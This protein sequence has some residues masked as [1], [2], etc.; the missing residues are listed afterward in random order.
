MTRA[1]T[2]GLVLATLVVTLLLAF[3]APLKA[4]ECR[5]PID[6]VVADVVSE[7]GYLVDLIDVRSEHFDQLLV[8]VAKNKDASRLIIG[9]VKDGCMVTGPVPLDTVEPVT[10]A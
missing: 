9:G 10:G 5:D 7:G 1:Q 2:I 3:C 8:I 6:K 4:Q